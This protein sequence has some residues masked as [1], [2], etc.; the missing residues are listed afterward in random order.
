[1]QPERTENKGFA[2]RQAN[3]RKHN[4]IRQGKGPH[5]EPGQ[6]NPIGKNESQ[7]QV[8]V[9]DTLAPTARRGRGEMGG[10]GMGEGEGNGDVDVLYK[11][12]IDC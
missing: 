12:R 9:R 11:R 2:G 6:G 8:R 7:E 3:R 1:M 5:I 10:S 4:K